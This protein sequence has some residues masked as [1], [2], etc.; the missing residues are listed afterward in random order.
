MDT[1]V[2]IYQPTYYIAIHL[3]QNENITCKVRVQARDALLTLL[4]THTVVDNVGTSEVRGH[5]Y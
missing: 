2:A 1:L 5:T 3:R 4:S